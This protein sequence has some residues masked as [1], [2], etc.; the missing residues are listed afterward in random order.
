V[1]AYPHRPLFSQLGCGFEGG[2]IYLTCIN[3]DLDDPVEVAKMQEDNPAM[4]LVSGH[5]PGK[6]NLPSNILFTQPTTSV[7]LDHC[8]SS[9]SPASRDPIGCIH[10]NQDRT[11]PVKALKFHRGSLRKAIQQ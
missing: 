4:S 8:S 7:A 3:D 1:A 11:R 10:A 9:N 5:P 6:H 2:L